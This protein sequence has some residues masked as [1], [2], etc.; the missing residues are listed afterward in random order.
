M[1]YFDRFGVH[2]EIG[3]MVTGLKINVLAFSSPICTSCATS[4][5]LN[6]TAG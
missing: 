6:K 4:Y 5:L 2:D 3:K 1:G